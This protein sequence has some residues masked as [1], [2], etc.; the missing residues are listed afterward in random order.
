MFGAIT[1]EEVII[2]K[3][4]KLSK[5]QEIVFDELCDKWD[6][7]SPLLT[8][9]ELEKYPHGESGEAYFSLTPLEIIQVVEVFLKWAKKNLR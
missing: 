9:S 1:E 6:Y 4:G 8:I 2:L 5:K 3:F 7:D